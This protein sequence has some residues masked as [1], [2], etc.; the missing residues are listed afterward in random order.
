TL[1]ECIQEG[2]SASWLDYN[3]LS[4]L[5]CRVKTAPVSVSGLQ[6]TGS[7]ILLTVRKRRSPFIAT[8]FANRDFWFQ[9]DVQIGLETLKGEIAVAPEVFRDALLL[10]YSLTVRRTSNM[11]DGM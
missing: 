6:Q 3:P 1:I 8:S 7:G 11:N 4:R 2:V 9:H 10:A 5:V